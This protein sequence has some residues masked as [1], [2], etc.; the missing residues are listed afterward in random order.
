MTRQHYVKGLGYFMDYLHLPH[1]A[2]DKLL[3]KDPKHIQMDICDFVTYLRKRGNASASVSVYVAAVNKFY[4]MNDIILNWKKIRSFMGEH[5][6]TVED[7]PYTHSEIQTLIQHAS[8]R[9]KAMILLMS[10]AGLRIGAISTLKIKD[11]EPIDKYNIYK[12]S[13]YSRSRKSRYFSFCTPE[14]RKSIENY[15]EYRRRWEERITEE[16][17]LFRT[18]FNNGIKYIS[19]DRGKQIIINILRDTGLRKPPIEGKTQRSHIMGNHGFRKFFETNAFKAGMD[20]MYLRRLMGQKS[21]L[22][23]SYLKLSEEELEAN[24]GLQKILNLYSM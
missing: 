2:Y 22:E 8:P 5:E 24:K 7:R 3:E 16:S 19:T 6:K 11:L 21:G 23:D 4:A 1:D 15:I 10:S 9:N 17:P 12:I 13:V 20:H 18:E 14:C